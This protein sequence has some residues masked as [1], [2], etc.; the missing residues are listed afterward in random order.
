MR[1]TGGEFAGRLIQAPKGPAIRPTLDHV[2]Q[3]LFNL[4]GARITGAKV[5]DLF[6]GSG[7]LGIEALSRGAAHA[8]FVDRSFF[9]AQAIEANLQSLGCQVDPTPF[10]LIRAE[11][12]TAIRRFKRETQLFDLILLD[13]PYGKHLARKS[14]NALGDYAIVG[15][16]GL[17]V[18]ET[19]KRDSLPEQ[20]RGKEAKLFLQ[21]SVRYGDTALS[22]YSRQ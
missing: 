10:T 6:A 16:L 20:I 9:C 15:Q 14:L 12:L 7:A 3:A 8:T 17:V 4:V 18:A 11:V 22:F 2:R 1:V 21:R 13:P 19:D 5:L